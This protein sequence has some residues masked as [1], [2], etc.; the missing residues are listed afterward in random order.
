MSR[1]AALMKNRDNGEEYHGFLKNLEGGDP[2]SR[3]ESCSG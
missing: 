1:P 3:H 2:M